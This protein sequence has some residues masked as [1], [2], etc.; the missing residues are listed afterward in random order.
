MQPKIDTPASTYAAYAQGRCTQSHLYASSAWELTGG[1]SS[2][3]TD[4]SWSSDRYMGWVDLAVQ[5]CLERDPTTAFVS[6]WYDAG[7]RC[8][9]SGCV[10]NGHSLPCPERG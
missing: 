10:A 9:G 2:G 6:V 5:K 8:Y 3:G 1:D 4:A 7:Y